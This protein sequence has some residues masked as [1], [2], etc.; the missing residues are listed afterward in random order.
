MTDSYSFKPQA[1]V[2]YGVYLSKQSKSWI[3][4]RQLCF[5]LNAIMQNELLI[6]SVNE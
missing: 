3:R 4:L 5:S 1:P 6:E 2:L